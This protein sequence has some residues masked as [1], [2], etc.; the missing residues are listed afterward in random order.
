MW[1]DLFWHHFCRLLL[2]QAGENCH[3]MKLSRRTRFVF[4]N[5][6]NV[7]WTQPDTD[8]RLPVGFT[9][10][11]TLPKGTS[12]VYVPDICTPCPH[13]VPA[14]PQLSLSPRRPIEPRAPQSLCCRRSVWVPVLSGCRCRSRPRRLPDSHFQTF[15]CWLPGWLHRAEGCLLHKDQKD[16]RR[17][18]LRRNVRR[19]AHARLPEIQS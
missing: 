13:L 11:Q 10:Q 3:S 15:L 16:N 6:P 12:E 18:S 17:G 19:S 7:T 14:G 1:H 9:R 4:L 2:H 5:F 8:Q